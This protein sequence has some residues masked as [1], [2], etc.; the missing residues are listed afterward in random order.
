MDGDESFAEGVPLGDEQPIPRAAQVF[1]KRVNFRS[2]D[3]TDFE[4]DMANYSSAELSSDQLEKQFRKDEL[5]GLMHPTTEAAVEA[6]YGPGRLLVA[7]M[8]AVSKPNGEVRPL[9]DGTH[10]I[11]LNNKIRVLDRLEVPGPNE[12][13]E[14]TAL[15]RESKEAVFAISADIAQAHRRVRVRRADWP[16]LGCRASSSSRTIWINRVGTFGIASAAYWWAR[17]FGLVGRWVLRLMLTSFNLQMV[18]V[19]DLRLMTA[20]A[21]KFINLWMILAAYEVVGTPFAYHKFRGGLDV[22]YIGY[23]LSYSIWSAG[24]SESRAAWIISWIDKAAESSW[25]VVGRSVIELTGRLTFVSRILTWLKP[26][27]AP[28]HAWC[29]VLARGTACRMPP[30]VHLSLV[31]L[32]SRLREGHRM[33][34]APHKATQLQQL[35]RTDA[36][37]EVGRIVLGGWLLGRV[38]SPR[39]AGWFCLVLTPSDAP[40]LFKPDG[41]S[42][43]ASASAELLATYLACVV[44]ASRASPSGLVLPAIIT[45][46]TDNR[47]NPQAL[48]K[49]SSLKWPLMG[50]LMQF[51][52]YLFTAGA[53]LRLQW[54]PREENVEADDITNLRFERFSLCNRIEASP[55]MLPMTIFDSMQSAHQDFEQARANQKLQNP[56]R[57][58]ATKKQKLA[59]KTKW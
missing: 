8:G 16:K 38:G 23:H 12:A 14:M 54:R 3:V 10:G 7:A 51:S 32:R 43:W 41:S 34:P 52:T 53:R 1:R 20:G 28:L 30:L 4:P 47:S 44:F 9:H 17:L 40:W 22:D 27:L 24:I 29:S 39:D 21:H 13:V 33:V 18:Y 49:G 19:D 35:F 37:C 5:A 31:F 58:P 50:I 56:V 59:E 26:F 11:G 42:Q 45:A 2:L 48:E 57:V 55:D 36:K 25:V 15:G 46:G 6:E